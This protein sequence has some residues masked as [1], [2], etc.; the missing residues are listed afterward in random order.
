MAQ[1]SPVKGRLGFGASG[2][3]N[4]FEVVDDETARATVDAAWDCGIRYFDT[5]PHYGLGLSEVRLGAALAGR[6]RGDYVV[7]T[8]VG[9][10]LV[11]TSTERVGDLDAEGFVV[12]A[13]LRRV[14]DPSEAGIRQS[15][16]ASLVRLG[17]DQIDI[18]YLHDPESYDVA[19]AVELALPALVRLREEGVV[20]AIGVGS[21]S[22]DALSRCVESVPLDLVMVAGRYTLLEQPAAGLLDR[23]LELGTGVV[24]V[25]VFNSGLLARANVA[26][27][28]RYDYVQAPPR[29]L[30]RA[31]ELAAVCR[32]YGVEL[33]TAALHFALRHPAVLSILVGANRPEYVREAAQR[34][35]EPVPDE[36][37]EALAPLLAGSDA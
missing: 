20:R 2:L 14:W 5:A 18:A 7:S 3:G 36:L 10:V 30:A 31:R 4:L 37:W 16:E 19:S 23:C 9:R 28:A 17:L 12:P 25:G 21:N 6:P 33:P 11:P 15:L 1:D 13:S 32:A 34:L 27:D 26:D 22:V 35:A 29:L 24:N 8:K